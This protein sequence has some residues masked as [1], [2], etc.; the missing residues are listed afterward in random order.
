MSASLFLS[1]IAASF[2]ARPLF[3]GLDLRLTPGDV[4]ALV[5]PNGAGKT[6]LLRIAAGLHTPDAGAVRFAP[7]DA[8]L[9]YLPQEP[10]APEE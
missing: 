4:T 3:S 8:T 7:P 6:T 9:G 10:P 1:G 5:G 2:G